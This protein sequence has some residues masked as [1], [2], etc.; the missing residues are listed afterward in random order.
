[1][2]RYKCIRCKE[3]I[4]SGKIIGEIEIKCMNCKEDNKFEIY[5]QVYEEVVE[6]I[7]I[8]KIISGDKILQ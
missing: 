3:I 6:E 7:G 8:G 5:K 1:M 4:F 2:R